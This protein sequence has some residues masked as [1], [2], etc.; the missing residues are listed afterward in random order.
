MFDEG[1]KFN[2]VPYDYGPFDREVYVESGALELAELVSSNRSP[3]GYTEYSVTDAGLQKA[4]ELKDA[5]IPGDRDYVEKV[6]EWVRSLSFAKLVKSIYE[7][8]PE[9]RAN[10]VFVG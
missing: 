4:Q 5:M 10:S 7:A 8:Y 1:S 3:N 2:F 9:M 6:V